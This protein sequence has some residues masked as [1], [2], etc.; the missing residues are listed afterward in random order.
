[1]TNLTP[2]DHLC[3]Q[4]MRDI[5]EG[6]YNE[7]AIFDVVI[8]HMKGEPFNHNLFNGVISSG[9]EKGNLQKEQAIVLLGIF[10]KNIV[11]EATS[12]HLQKGILIGEERVKKQVI[13]KL[14]DDL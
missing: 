10:I 12:R 1:M 5:D 9:S 6:Q 3:L 7:R 13:K 2:L 11:S 4:I 8:R 14:F